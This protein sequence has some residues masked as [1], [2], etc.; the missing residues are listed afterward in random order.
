M[1]YHH[2]YL[3]YKSKY[4][5]IMKQNGN[6]KTKEIYLIRHG[7]TDWNKKK[8]SMGQEADIPLNE[9]G[10][11][12]A[13]KTGLYLKNYRLD[14]QF[15]CI[16]ASPMLRAKETA[17]IIK[18]IIGFKNN[19]I[20][21]D[22]LKEAKIGKFSGIPKDDT[23]FQKYFKREKEE[24]SKDPI[25]KYIQKTSISEKL[26]K[27]FYTGEESDNDIQIRATEIMNE[28][29]KSDCNK[30]MIISH[31]NL[32]LSLLRKL[33]KVPMVPPGNLDNGSNCFISFITYDD[34]NGFTM[35]SPPDTEHLGL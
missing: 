24:M 19:I 30:I 6:G 8:L 18:D 33:F 28:I 20:F 5:K 14:K 27:E 26:S 4:T 12:Q 1:N 16:Y 25:E 11:D 35:I 9:L 29:I 13:R 15:D 32:L 34:K 31:G 7:E 10:K 17:E 21:D 2:K 23:L 22:R 3:K